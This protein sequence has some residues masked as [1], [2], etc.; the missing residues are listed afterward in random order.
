M[1]F[2]IYIMEKT[3]NYAEEHKDII[4]RKCNAVFV[5]WWIIFAI[6]LLLMFICLFVLD[7]WAK[8]NSSVVGFFFLVELIVAIMAFEAYV[9]ILILW[10][11]GV[12]IES[13]ILI[14]SK[15]EIPYDKIN[16]VSIRSAF[17]FGALEIQVGNDMV[18]RYNFLDKYE[19]AE[20]LIKEKI[21]KNKS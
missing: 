7:L 13:G 20:K 17:W 12:I 21:S 18:T 5:F 6:V 19:E 2:K 9:N 8:W 3:K 10:K 4:F 15:K 1:I 16:S 11:D 14:K